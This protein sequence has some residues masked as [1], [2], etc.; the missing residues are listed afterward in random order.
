M[1]KLLL[2]L[3]VLPALCMAQQVPPPDIAAKAWLLVDFASGQTLAAQNADA[4]AEPASLTKLMTAY[5]AFQALQQKTLTLTQAV[6]VSEH[7]WKALGSR[8]FIQPKLPVTVDELLRGMIVQS[9]NDASIALAEAIAGSEGA[10]A[11]MMNQT[12]QR[13]GMKNTHYVNATG[14][15]DPEHYSTARDLA[16]LASALIRDFPDNYTLYS[17]KEYKYNNIRQPNRNRLLWLDPNVDGVKTGHT[18]NAGFCL[19]ASAKRGNRRVLS[20]LLGAVSD[21]ARAIESQK[22]LNHAF[23]YYDTVR[24]YEKGQQLSQLQ[25]WKG[26]DSTVKAGFDSDLYLT[27]PKGDADKVKANLVSQQPLIAPISQGQQ[28]AVLK[29]TVDG[30]EITDIPVRALEAVGVAGPIG[31]AWDTLRLWFK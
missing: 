19:V 14:L 16:T 18:D 10:F 12:A 11:Q 13:M 27:V 23:Q 22:L 24:L 21:S 3:L 2:L 30:K 7:A 9:G 20:V 4:R 31:R 8:M 17:I 1:R 15:P 28:V 25:V 29:V 6:P 5:L 26:A